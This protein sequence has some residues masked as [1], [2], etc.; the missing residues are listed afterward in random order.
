MEYICKYCNKTYKSIHSRSNHYRIY[1]DDEV[2]ENVKV[3]KVNVSKNV[4]V[5]KVVKVDILNY[6]CNFCNKEFKSRQYKWEH[7]NKFCK[8]RNNNQ[9]STLDNIKKENDIIKK[10]NEDIKSKNLELT[11]KFDQL[12][13]LFKIHPKILQKINK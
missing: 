12:L 8:F 7:Q 3:V 1:H 2:K 10:E 9:E 4:K 6:T 11:N 13:K 5:V